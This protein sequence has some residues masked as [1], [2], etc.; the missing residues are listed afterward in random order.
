MLEK[1]PY[2]ID[3]VPVPLNFLNIK[4]TTET[5]SYASFLDNYLD[6]GDSSNLHSKIYEKRDDFNF[7]L[8]ISHFIVQ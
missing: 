1:V 2:I 6:F 5:A 8:Y 4:E 3:L 7:K